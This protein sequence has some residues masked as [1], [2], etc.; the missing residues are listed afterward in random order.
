M[1]PCHADY[2][3]EKAITLS[4]LPHQL[5]VFDCPTRNIVYVK[6]RRAGGTH[7]AITRLVELAHLHPRSCHLWIDTSY[8]NIHKLIA[9]Y[10]SPCLKGSE[11]KW[12]ASDHVLNFES[13]SWCDFGSAER[14]EM[15]EGFAYD[16][17]WINEAGLVLR[18]ESIYYH[19]LLPMLIESP[20]ARF[21]CIGAPKGDGLFRRMFDWGQDT[22]QQDW[23]SFRHP[24]HINPLLSKKELEGLQKQM[25]RAVYQQEIMAEFA[26]ENQKVFQSLNDIQLVKMD[27]APKVGHSYILGVDLAR[28]GDFTVAWVG[29]V[30]TRSTVYCERFHR[31]PWRGQLERLLALS[32]RFNYAPLYVDASG[33]GDP[34]CEEM[35]RMGAE[36]YPVVFTHSRKQQLVEL[37][38]LCMEQGMLSLAYHR[39]TMNELA[40]YEH[41]RLPSGFIRTSAPQGQH[42]DCVMA[43]ALCCWGINETRREF[44]LGNPHSESE[45]AYQSL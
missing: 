6:G 44:I 1:L 36:A 4:Y 18:D 3:K 13:G 35:N 38:A 37:L 22:Q 14:P 27:A 31:I 32:R 24:S 39:E 42:D 41:Y 10:F 25:P 19:T 29:C 12:D 20:H 40:A 43:L 2:T 5:E 15:L 9:R 7:G 8:R 17:I 23:A 45:H 21:F 28:W 33:S 30:D 34:I 16:Y 11:W 26:N